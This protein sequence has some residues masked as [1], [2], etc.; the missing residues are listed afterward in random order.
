VIGNQ[1]ARAVAE[2]AVDGLDEGWR[3]H[4]GVGQL[5]GAQHEA[6]FSSHVARRI[7]HAAVGEIGHQDLFTRGPAQRAQHRVGAGGRVVHENQILAARADERRG[8]IGRDAQ[9]RPLGLRRATPYAGQLAE[10]VARGA[11]VRRRCRG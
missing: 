7:H 1:E 4:L 6:V 9:A 5:D 2:R 3:P 8:G 10:Q 11:A